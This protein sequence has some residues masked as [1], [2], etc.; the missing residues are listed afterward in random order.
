MSALLFNF[1][2]DWVMRRT[3]E[4]E[5]KGIKWTP[6]FTL[7]DLDFADDLALI[8]HTH[9]HMQNKTDK[10]LFI[11]QQV[12]LKITQQKTEVMIINVPSPTPKQLEKQDLCI[13]DKFTYLGSILSIDGS[14]K[15][16]IKR[17][18][19]KARNVFRSMTTV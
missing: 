4:A 10:L 12:G 6:F 2:I 1:T 15:K 13:T 11:G 3:R 9:R 8:S 18:L 14:A 7:N 5:T 17:R 16:D 19:N